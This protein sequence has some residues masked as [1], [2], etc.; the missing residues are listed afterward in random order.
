M[1][2]TD[3]MSQISMQTNIVESTPIENEAQE[4]INNNE[5]IKDLATNYK[6]SNVNRQ[7]RIDE[8]TEDAFGFKGP[9]G[10]KKDAV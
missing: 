3:P 7:D 8:G 6:R 10:R 2:A 4:I 1:A 5:L 9:K